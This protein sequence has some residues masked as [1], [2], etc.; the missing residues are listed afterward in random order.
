[1]N[2]SAPEH[3]VVM[4]PTTRLFRRRDSRFCWVRSLSGK[5]VVWRLYYNGGKTRYDVRGRVEALELAAYRAPG[6]RKYMALKLR[7]ARADLRM[8]KKCA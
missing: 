1:M 3:A 4:R 5:L 8:G 6:A 7:R 2:V